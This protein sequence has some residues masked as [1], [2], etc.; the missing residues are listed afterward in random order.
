MFP[1]P[2]EL[3]LNGCSIESIWTPNSKSSTLTPKPTCRHA[4]KGKFYT[5]WVESSFVFVQHQ[6]FQF[7][8]LF[9]SNVEKNAKRFRWRKSHSKVE[10]DDEF[11]LAMQRKD[12]WCATF[13]CI[14]NPREN[15]IRK[16]YRFRTEKV[17]AMTKQV[18]LRFVIKRTSGRIR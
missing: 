4:D 13:D 15:Q 1:G 10:A 12:S 17:K 9:W 5:W 2:T 3:R 8:R 11:G 18:K 7:Y 16:S 14:R 6:P